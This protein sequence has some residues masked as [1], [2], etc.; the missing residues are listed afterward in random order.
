MLLACCVSS[1]FFGCSNEPRFTHRL[2]SS[3][4]QESRTSHG[5][6]FLFS[7]NSRFFKIFS[8]TCL[9]SQ[10]LQDVF[11]KIT[12]FPR[13]FLKKFFSQPRTSRKF[14]NQPR[15]LMENKQNHEIEGTRNGFKTQGTIWIARNLIKGPQQFDN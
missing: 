14:K 5:S 15:I 9:G 10:E 1:L 8:R 4:N 6:F 7:K 2:I 11:P 12:R 13:N 3:F